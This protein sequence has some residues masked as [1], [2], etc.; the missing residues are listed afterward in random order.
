MQSKKISFN[1][2][3]CLITIVSLIISSIS[4][5]NV[6]SNNKKLDN[7]YLLQSQDGDS[8]LYYL[9]DNDIN[10]ISNRVESELTGYFQTQFDTNAL[11]LS[12]KNSKLVSNISQDIQN[13]LA[14]LAVTTNYIT[15]A[16]LDGIIEGIVGK[17]TVDYELTDERKAEIEKLASSAS[18]SSLNELKNT[19]TQ[20]ASSIDDISS[21]T[22][23][24]SISISELKADANS[25]L[26]LSSN[27]TNDIQYL[28]TAVSE[29]QSET[30]NNLT[31]IKSSVKTLEV[32]DLTTSEGISNAVAS[33]NTLKTDLASSTQSI[34]TST[35]TAIN[36]LIK[37][38]ES[39][40]TLLNSA[41]GTNNGT[42]TDK[43]L[44]L[45]NTVSAQIVLIE[46]TQ[47][48]NLVNLSKEL[49]AQIDSLDLSQSE[50]VTNISI[51]L[52]DIENELAKLYKN[53]EISEKNYEDLAKALSDLK[54]YTEEGLYELSTSLEE[55]NKLI[56]ETDERL[57]AQIQDVSSSL[58]ASMND[59]ENRMADLE[60]SIVATMCDKLYPIGSIYTSVTNTNPSELFGGTWIEWGS[61]KVPV[62]VDA[63][64]DSYDIV[65]KTGGS[66]TTVLTVENL[67][68]H[69]HTYN[70]TG[71]PSGTVLS[72]TTIVN[73]GAHTHTFS[74]T[75]TPTASASTSVAIS[76]TSGLSGK[77][78]NFTIEGTNGLETV[79]AKG[80]FVPEASDGNSEMAN[81]D[82]VTRFT[83]TSK[84]N[85]HKDIVSMDVNHSHSASA[86]TSVTVSPFSL[87]G[88]TS[89]S[90]N[91]THTATTSSSF[92]GNSLT[93]SGSTSNVGN[94]TELDNKQS[95]ITCYMF[96]RIS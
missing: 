85:A 25:A 1:K 92:T 48:A 49:Q 26:Q 2:I 15:K 19:V 56:K 4:I 41:I 38:L 3:L 67:P 59:L 64:N 89:S 88:T 62:G 46:S 47:A 36:D 42:L 40:L 17:I 83:T 52:N 44:S 29:L 51:K 95:Y 43:I 9:N 28:K 33:I 30:L 61:G 20:L 94:A 63:T 68:S 90:G 27:N 11:S 71:A 73:A 54:T 75:G 14:N 22:S 60:S 13:E 31:T 39:N 8:G 81:S 69:S 24:N 77:F 80:I 66:D 53:D 5:V 74:S 79:Y 10:T 78:G 96:K 6:S 57:T 58:T 93:V 86:S 32:A 55:T 21:K 50:N 82:A 72:N 65:E 34:S 35:S 37:S 84:L 12:E 45:S 70:W 16:D 7:L 87:S 23:T 76:A 91:H 18:R